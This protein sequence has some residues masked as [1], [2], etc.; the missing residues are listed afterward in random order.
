M[1]STLVIGGGPGGL[2]PLIWAAQQGLL[3]AWLDRGLAIVDRQGHLGGTL[4]RFGINSDSLGGSYLECLD[5]PGLPRSLR[6]LRFDPVSHEMARYRD[7]FPPLELV[8]R[9]MRRLGG[10]IET[11]VRDH[12]NA[13]FRP[14]TEVKVLRLRRDGAV[15][16]DLHAAHG[17]RS[18]LV[19]RSVVVALGGRQ[20]WPEP[21]LLFDLTMA[22]CL[23]T[24]D[25]LL[26]RAG[27]GEATAIL[28]GV[29]A[30]RIVILGGSHSAYSAAWALLQLPGAE[31]LGRGQIVILQRQAPPVFYPD[32][33]AAE[34]DLYPVAPD[35]ICP[36]TRRVNRL[37]GLRGNGRDLWR[38]IEQRP[39][40]TPERRV[41]A[42]PLQ[43][44]DADGLRD[45]I[46]RA[47]L[48][49]TAFGYRAA[50]VPIFDIDGRRL[51]LS[52]DSGGASV[53]AQCRMMLADGSVLP[54]V[55]GIGLGSGYRP[56]GSMGG[57][58]S[59]KG[60]ANSLWLYQHD[61]GAVI[62]RAIHEIERAP[63]AALG[64]ASD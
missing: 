22:E 47:A 31:R 23:M 33:E 50:S 1:L 51:A 8:D 11:I 6:N 14:H 40:A 46:G 30:R 41:M 4:G 44:V 26:A 18:T 20:N 49:V 3:P 21:P 58:A 38:Q 42:M 64:V 13:D 19:A 10:A 28:A 61:I 16:A 27:L 60:Q 52:A 43:G 12:G 34:A 24:S 62:Y 25:R 17:G 9:Y 39:G 59:F 37:G 15:E 63:E 5:A 36:R 56:T 2:G 29:G 32:R 53:D 57:E 55:F 45:M 54:N 7:G 48:V 35:D